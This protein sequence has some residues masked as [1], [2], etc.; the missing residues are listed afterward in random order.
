MSIHYGHFQIDLSK[1]LDKDIDSYFPCREC[2]HWTGKSC[3][4][5]DDSDVRGLASFINKMFEFIPQ[6]CDIDKDTFHLEGELSCKK[7]EPKEKA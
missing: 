5:V 3:S 4:L 1:K 6:S 7:M 2:K